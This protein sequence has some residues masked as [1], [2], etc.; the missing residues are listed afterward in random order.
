[1]SSLCC[2]S[3]RLILAIGQRLPRHQRVL[4][5]TNTINTGILSSRVARCAATP[6]LT[7]FF[8]SNPVQG[9]G[10]KWF[11]DKTPNTTTTTTTTTAI[12]GEEDETSPTATVVAT[13]PGTASITF[14]DDQAEP[15]TDR[16]AESTLEGDD[17]SLYNVEIKIRMPDMGEGSGGSDNKVVKWYKQ[18]GDIIK[19]N[20]ILCDIE[21][22]DFSFGM[23][24][25]DEFDSIMGEIYVK[26]G[27]EF[28]KNGTVICNVWHQGEP[29]EEETKKE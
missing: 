21:T 2:R 6:S 24:T 8:A 23:V 22:P 25:E 5:G 15:N 14:V 17:R 1:M 18:T 9:Q 28:V 19:R 10:V 27:P 29:G 16:H 13:E 12:N 26:E 3:S 11:S 4:F 7:A 20:D